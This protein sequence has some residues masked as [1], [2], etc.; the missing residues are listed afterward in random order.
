MDVAELTALLQ[1]DGEI[2][3]ERLD[4]WAA[5]AGDRV[6]FHYGEDDVT[7][8]Y[9]EFAARTDCIA[10]NLAAQGITKGDRV[11]VFCTN[12][13]VSA[14]LMFGIWKAGAVY[15]PVNFAYSGRLLSYQLN[16]TAPRLVVT[17]ARLLSAL[18]AVAAELT[19]PPTVVVHE[20]AVG[21]H[22]HVDRREDVA[23]ALRELDWSALTAPAQRPAVEVCFDDPANVVYTSGTTGPA[24]GVVQPYRWMAQYTYGLR[25]PLTSDDVI[26]N[27]L[28]MYHVGGAIANV[29]R[30]AWVGCEVAVWD[31]F[32]PNA[33]WS[34]VESRGAT[35]VILL[36]VMI[37][38]LMKAPA[39]DA[40]R[41]NTLNKAYMQ[42]LPLHH[43]E[44][45]RRFGFDFVAAGFGQT[46]SGAPLGLLIEQ[47][48]QGDGTPD[49]LYR[50][51]SH[52][53]IGEVA[54]RRGLPV[55]PGANVR[56]KGV[57]GLPGPFAQVAVLDEH[58]RECA[59]EQAGQL[60]LRPHLPG[61]VMSEYLGKP[62]AT[63]NAWRNLWLHTGDVAVRGAD[64]LFYFVDRLG[65]RMRVRGEN[66]S[67]FQ[68]EDLLNRHPKV[69][70]CAVFAIRGAEGNEDDVVACV[71]PDEG[72]ELGADE[73][74]AY[75]AATMPKY[76]RPRIVR[77]LDNLPRT[78]TNKVEKY[79]LRELVLA[80]LGSTGALGGSV[81]AG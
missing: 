48:A 61:L 19:D 64:G 46:E 65:D 38:W 53:E 81:E 16:D 30:A 62:D 32:S 2:V 21:A 73:I 74:H 75:A 29:A 12:P 66:L 3:A 25:A 45:A 54:R 23:G 7:L 27:D 6:F 1:A 39:S 40:D 10:G 68:V 43:A 71:V 57:M 8:T 13:L 50:G 18:N 26:Y 36:D 76:M 17:D 70:Y 58:D 34:R 42:P 20:T 55:L 63:V 67:S 4:H 28:P 52:A 49:Q 72:A 60:A 35:T 79:K 59:D 15:C 37:P 69:R 5:T 11:S 22:D 80:E 31:R 51:L 56:R 14:L 41:H 78:A 77:I 44:V 24:K 33:F 47:T 9:A